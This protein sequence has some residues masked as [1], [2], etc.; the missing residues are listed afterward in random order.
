MGSCVR[1]GKETDFHYIY[2]TGTLVNTEYTDKEIYKTYR[3]VSSHEHFLCGKCVDW[4]LGTL[5]ILYTICG[6]SVSGFLFMCFIILS[7]IMRKGKTEIGLI[8]FTCVPIAGILLTGRLIAGLRKDKAFNENEGSEAL[9]KIMC[10]NAKKGEKYFTIEEH[11]RL[12]KIP[13]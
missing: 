5:K 6:L 2:Y 3:N 9:V 7:D 12:F 10:R 1:C 13:V 11:K 4:S 8:I